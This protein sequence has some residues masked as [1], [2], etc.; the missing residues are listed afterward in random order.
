M[1]NRDLSNVPHTSF[2]DLFE[3][4]KFVYEHEFQKRNIIGF[5]LIR[6]HDVFLDLFTKLRDG[7]HVED[8]CWGIERQSSAKVGIVAWGMY[9]VPSIALND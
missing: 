4:I 7:L 9:T 5:D 3:Q 6:M 8:Q 2:A 1:C